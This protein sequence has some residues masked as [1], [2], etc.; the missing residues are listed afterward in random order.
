MLFM[1]LESSKMN[2]LAVGGE[3]SKGTVAKFRNSLLP[4]CGFAD[5]FGAIPGPYLA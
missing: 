1:F 3:G 4:L 5:V 2:Y